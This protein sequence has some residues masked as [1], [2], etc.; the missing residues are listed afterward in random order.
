MSLPAGDEGPATSV[1][2]PTTA[3]STQL[4]SAIAALPLAEGETDLEQMRSLLGPPDAFT[5]ELDVTGAD[6]E[7]RR[8]EWFYFELLSVY[9]FVDGRLVSNLPLE[10]G[11][12]LIAPLQYDPADFTLGVG[13]EETA[14]GLPDAAEFISYEIEDEFEVEA[15]YYVGSQLLL[16]FDE[17]GR[18]AYVETLPLEAEA[19]Q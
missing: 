18:L 11:G 9:E 17:S 12:F 5:L 7:S 1:A 2:S 8:E 6:G 19:P 15:T 13:W 14:A 16:V 4:Q 10:E 3:V